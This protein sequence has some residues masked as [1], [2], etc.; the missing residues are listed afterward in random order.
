[1]MKQAPTI[2]DFPP[3]LSGETE[4]AY[5]KRVEEAMCGDNI[6]SRADLKEWTGSPPFHLGSNKD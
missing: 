5:W 4:K 2:T 1:M 3:K 6:R